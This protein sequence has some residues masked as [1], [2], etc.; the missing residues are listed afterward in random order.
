MKTPSQRGV[1]LL[2][3]LVFTILMSLAAS[4]VLELS[5]NS[6]R[7]SQ[8]NLLRAQARAVAES[9]LEYTYFLFEGQ[10]MSSVSGADLAAALA[11]ANIADNSS[12]PTTVRTAYSAQHQTD[13]WIIRRSISFDVPPGEMY[14]IIPGTSKTGLFAYYTVKVEVR[15]PTSNPFASTVVMRVGRRMNYSSTSIF[16]YNVFSQGDLEMAP[17]G[18]TII[19]GDIAS[20]GNVYLASSHA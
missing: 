18:N 11:T 16:Q 1:V 4:S 3:T 9:E 14:G 8:R 20:N 2:A 5:M 15:P 10:V 17:G 13:G 12:T 19:N 6:Y 7:L